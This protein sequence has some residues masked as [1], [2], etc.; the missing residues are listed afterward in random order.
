MVDSSFVKKYF[1]PKTRMQY[2]T[3]LLVLLSIKTLWAFYEISSG[4][5]NLDPD[6]AQYWTWSRNLDFGFY[7]KPPGIAW[8]IWLGCKLFGQ[9]ELGIRSMSV[10][11]SILTSFAIYYGAVKSEIL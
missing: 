9:T 5:I 1:W 6:E 7:S 3:W 10:L 11:V 8:Q 4:Y 2:L